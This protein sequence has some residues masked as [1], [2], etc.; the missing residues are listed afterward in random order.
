MTDTTPSFAAQLGGTALALALVL[1]LAWLALRGLKQ[2]QLRAG[3][4]AGPGAAPQVLRST[5]LGPR[6]RVVVL[7]HRGQDYLLG[8]TPASV[9]LLDRWPA[10]AAP[11]QGQPDTSG[12]P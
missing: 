10:D 5:P 3:A 4:A 1:A 6:E 2:L 11:A 7:R 9:Q 12:A 8:V